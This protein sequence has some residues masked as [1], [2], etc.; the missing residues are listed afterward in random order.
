MKT[1]PIG[2]VLFVGAEPDFVSIL[3]FWPCL[4]RM[5]PDVRAPMRSVG[6]SG[7]GCAEA[8]GDRLDRAFTALVVQ[9][10]RSGEVDRSGR[11]RMRER[12]SGE[13]RSGL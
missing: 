11:R 5:V 12:C 1:L 13:I 7:S 10:D 6:E 2:V 8:V 4:A 9:G 3:K